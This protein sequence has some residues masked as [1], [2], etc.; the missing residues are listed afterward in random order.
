MRARSARA[1]PRTIAGTRISVDADFKMQWRREL[2]AGRALVMARR[3]AK[4]R[5]AFLGT[6]EGFHTTA[7][8][9]ADALNNLLA[10]MRAHKDTSAEL[11]Q[12]LAPGEEL[13]LKF[14]QI[15]GLLDQSL[16][17]SHCLAGEP[18]VWDDV[19]FHYAHPHPATDKLKFCH[20]PWRAR[21]RR[22]SADPQTCACASAVE[23]PRS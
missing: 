16:S 2:G 17:C 9:P 4:F 5:A 23:A 21:C 11:L 13:D 19:L 18:S 10:T 22:C 15:A 7:S 1:S 20:D 3:E 8:S 14:Q 12:A 6:H